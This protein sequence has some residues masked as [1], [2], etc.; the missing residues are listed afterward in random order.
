MGNFR[1]VQID[2]EGLTLVEPKIFTD[3]RGDFAETYCKR[4]FEQGGITADFVQDNQ[5]FSRK[6]VIRGLHFQKK[7]PQ[8][9]LV[10]VLSGAVYDVAVDL[11]PGSKTFGK[12]FGVELSSQNRLQLYIPE[13]FA[14]G[15]QALSDGAEFAYKCTRCYVPEDEG[16]IRW[17]D[18]EISIVWRL[19]AGVSPILSEKDSRLPCFKDVKQDLCRLSEGV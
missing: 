3:S 13:G 9:K 19:E 2:I 7:N 5:S 14:H 1:F 8:G 6:N 10:R 16:G 12:W 17:D 4:D 18:P 15:F 11:R